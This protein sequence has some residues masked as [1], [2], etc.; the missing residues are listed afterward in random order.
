[1]YIHGHYHH[2]KYQTDW[3]SILILLCA[4]PPAEK[5]NHQ[6]AFLKVVCHSSSNRSVVSPNLVSYRPHYLLGP[7][8]QPLYR[9]GNVFFI[10]MNFDND[11]CWSVMNI[12]L[13]LVTSGGV[14]LMEESWVPKG[15]SAICVC[16]GGRPKDG[17]VII[18]LCRLK[19]ERISCPRGSGHVHCE[20][21][22]STW[23]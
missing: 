10:K 17:V 21:H 7:S 3:D 12:M 16:N 18:Q 4:Y 5:P 11:A 19:I 23:I 22:T 6:L 20:G 2:R 15:L 9:I 8:K 14:K 13:A 1:M